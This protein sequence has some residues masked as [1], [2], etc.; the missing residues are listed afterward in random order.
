MKTYAFRGETTLATF[1][2]QKRATHRKQTSTYREKVQ[3]VSKSDPAKRAFSFGWVLT[4]TVGYLAMQVVLGIVAQT[5]VLPFVVAKHT[6]FFTEGLIIM[7][8][9][10]VGA[11]LIG[12]IS[13]G[14]RVVEPVLGAVAAVAAAFSVANFT[15]QMGGWL[16]HDGLGMMTTAA[17]LAAFF[18]GFGCYSGEKLMRNV[19]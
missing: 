5:F 4:S 2:E 10:Y 16:R 15:P 18:A 19:K 1:S 11:F 9:F 7:L 17:L 6:Q 13:P 12:V 14:R 8:G 3:V